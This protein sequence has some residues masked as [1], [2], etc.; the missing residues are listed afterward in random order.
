MNEVV[1]PAWYDC[2]AARDGRM[3]NVADRLKP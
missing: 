3:P 2:L 1:L